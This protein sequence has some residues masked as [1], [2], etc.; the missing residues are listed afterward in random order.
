MEGGRQGPPILLI[1]LLHKYI[2]SSLPLPPL[3][4]PLPPP[5]LPP[6]LRG[7]LYDAPSAAHGDLNTFLLS[8]THISNPCINRWRRS[9]LPPPADGARSS[10]SLT[11]AQLEGGSR[12]STFLSAVLLQ[13][14]MFI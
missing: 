12:L 14:Y 4:L 11:L 5:P 10:S 3:P 13:V 1:R 9:G 2:I 7:S 8:T 6:P